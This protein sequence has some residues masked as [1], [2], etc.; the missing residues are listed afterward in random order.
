MSRFRK[1]KALF[2]TFVIAFVFVFEYET[3]YQHIHT[4]VSYPYILCRI[5][6]GKKQDMEHQVVGYFG[7]ITG[8][9]ETTVLGNKNTA[10][11][12]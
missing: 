2:V 10:S 8:S 3:T 6:V 4:R 5:R 9:E 12:F 1:A 11:C 7:G